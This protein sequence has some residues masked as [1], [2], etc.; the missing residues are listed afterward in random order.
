MPVTPHA[1]MEETH[2]IIVCGPPS[3]G[4]SALTHRYLFNTFNI[5]NEYNPTLLETFQKRVAIDQKVCLLTITD[6]A[7]QEEYIALRDSALRNGDG[8]LVVFSVMDRTSFGEVRGIIQR[9]ERVQE[10]SGSGLNHLGAIVVCGNKCEGSQDGWE[11]QWSEVEAL[12]RELGVQ[13]IQTSAKEDVGVVEAFTE[14]IREIR[15]IGPA[16]RSNK[17]SKKDSKYA[18]KDSMF[19]NNKKR[20]SANIHNK[21]CVLL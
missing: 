15:R 6:T 14:L 12:I 16:V 7:G 10:S 8:F 5:N 13:C 1:P 19:S 21:G 18:S 17:G 9:I 2:D 11:V 3:V 4:K 20:S